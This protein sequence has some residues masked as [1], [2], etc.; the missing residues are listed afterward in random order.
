MS[1]SLLYSI[2]A[3]IKTCTHLSQFKQ[4]HAQIIKHQTLTPHFI[5]FHL[6]KLASLSALLT[7]HK[8]GITLSYANSIFNHLQNP[9]ISLYNSLIRA[10]SL[11]NHPIES[12]L[13]YRKMLRHGV[14]PNNYTFTFLIKGCGRMRGCDHGLM[15]HA[16]VVER[17]FDRDCH[18]QSSLIR[19]YAKGYD[20][21]S[22]RKVFEMCD[23]DD[24]VD[25]NC[26]IDGCVRCGDMGLA[27]VVFD[28][29]GCK[30]V[31]SW[32][33]MIRGY[34]VEG[35]VGEAE[36]MFEG[37][38]ER[39][40]VSWN[41]MLGVYAK[42]GRVDDA[43]GLLGRM[44]RRDVVSWNTMLAS[45][46]Q[47]GRGKEAMALFHE[48][49]RDGFVKPDEVTCA[50]VLSACAE[51]GALDQGKLV[52]EY[53]VERK[54]D[55]N[56]IVKTA[57]LDMYSQGGCIS[58]AVQVF[59]S[60]ENKDILAW[61]TMLSAMARHGR[62]KETLQ[63]FD[64]MREEG[65]EPNDMTFGALLS[66]CSHAG[67]VEEGQKLLHNMSST[68]RVDPKIEHYGCVIDLLARNG[69]LGEAI[70]LVESMP[71]EPNVTIWGALSAGCR[72]HSNIEVGGNVGK[73]LIDLEPSHGGRYVSLSTVYSAA[74]Q[75]DES[76]EVR[77]LMNGRKVHKV[78]GSST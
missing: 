18:V 27:R 78:S 59:H 13:L 55:A 46:K 3:L 36:K 33:V 38:P 56:P 6:S 17:G 52:H 34:S 11:G 42:C 30:D 26:M 16:H 76:S 19:V 1:Q 2:T 64:Q 23:G 9:P 41:L 58:E 5:T 68:Y 71:M 29:M 20:L 8:N 75:W 15:I 53:I 10:H 14:V 44:P 12:I 62:G 49:M 45:F 32:N 22:A 4:I 48:M 7:I 61:N 51:L 63:L 73:H 31:V 24:V 72:I 57:L 21:V 35:K 65:L 25:W 50:T 47:S 43:V 54:I 66:A 77:N 69:H 37:M 28:K 40:V 67:M 39:N 74:K 70:Q 60:I